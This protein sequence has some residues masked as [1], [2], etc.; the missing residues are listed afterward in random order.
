MADRVLVAFSHF[1]ATLFDS[2]LKHFLSALGIADAD[3]LTSQGFCRGMVQAVVRGR[4]A[5]ILQARDWCSSAFHS[6]VDRNEIDQLAILEL[7]DDEESERAL[8]DSCGVAT[9]E[10]PAKHLRNYRQATHL[11][12]VSYGETYVIRATQ[13]SVA[14]RSAKEEKRKGKKKMRK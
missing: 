14:R 3:K 9:S 1:S 2:S 10:E 4:L 12:R 11:F 6:Y 5:K 13:D 7:F 8:S